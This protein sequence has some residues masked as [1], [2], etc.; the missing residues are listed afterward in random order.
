MVRPLAGAGI[1]IDYMVGSGTTE[2]V[3]PLAGAGI[4]ILGIG[5]AYPLRLFAPSRGRELKFQQR[6][7]R[8]PPALVRPFTGAG[9]EIFGM[10]IIMTKTASS[11]L[12]GGGN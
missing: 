6:L 8:V 1:E 3:R 12:H 2:D 11:P 7:G 9:I 4:E 5:Y 10:P